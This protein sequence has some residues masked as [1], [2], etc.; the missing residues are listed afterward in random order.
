MLVFIF[1]TWEIVSRLGVAS[2]RC[3]CL[4]KKQQILWLT[5]FQASLRELSFPI[6]SHMILSTAAES[7]NNRLLSSFTHKH[8]WQAFDFNE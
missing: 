1:R 5:A 4:T 3:Q 2:A 8:Q 6:K 7:P